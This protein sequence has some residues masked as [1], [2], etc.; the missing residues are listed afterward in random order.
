MRAPRPV[1]RTVA[2]I[3]RPRERT[4]RRWAALPANPHVHAR[5][6][7]RIQAPHCV[8]WRPPPGTAAPPRRLRVLF[9]NV[10][11]LGAIEAVAARIRELEVDVALLA[12][13]DLGM[14]RTG[15]RHTVAELAGRLGMGYTFGVEFVELGLGSAEERRRHAG[16]RNLAG[17]HGNAILTAL[18]MHS[19]RMLRLENRGL[20]FDGQW[21]ERR[22]G[23]RMALL[24]ELP[25]PGGVLTCVCTHFESHTDPADR[26]AQMATLLAA[27]DERDAPRPVL[28][29]GDLNSSTFDLPSRRDPARV[30]AALMQDPSRLLDPTPYE[31][32]FARAA[33]AGFSWQECNPPAAPT[34]RPSR[35]RPHDIC[36]RIDWFL[37]RGLS[38]RNAILLPAVGPDGRELSDHDAIAVDVQLAKSADA[39]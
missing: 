29:G 4:R 36:G 30:R 28:I 15:N 27:L 6:C 39:R 33:R 18:P 8:E 25:L 14:A 5:L 35:S 13:V 24:A 17:L 3:S 12:E 32:L 2:R 20:W 9:W 26:D 16:A 19:P 23:G 38:C 7:A 22:I 31:P 1:G 34:L 10:A 37:T 11:R 21:G